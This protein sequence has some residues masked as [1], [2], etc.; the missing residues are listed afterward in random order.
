MFDEEE[1]T[2]GGLQGP[3]P[4]TSFAPMGAASCVGPLVSS[5]SWAFAFI[6]VDLGLCFSFLLPS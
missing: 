2:P 6:L 1:G 4:S 5:E 3:L